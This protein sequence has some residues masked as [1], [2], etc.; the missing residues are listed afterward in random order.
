MILGL[1]VCFLAECLLALHGHISWNFLVLSFVVKHIL[2]FRKGC[3]LRAY[4]N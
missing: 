4:N 1:S 2:S 3:Q